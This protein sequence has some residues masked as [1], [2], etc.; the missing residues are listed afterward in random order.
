MKIAVFPGSFDPITNGHCELVSRAAQLFDEIIIAVGVN[1]SKQYM[2]PLEQRLQWIRDS[3]TASNIKVLTY[4]G[5]TIDFCVEQKAAYILR[6]LRNNADLEYER[7]IAQANATMA[8]EIETVFLISSPQT[9]FISSSIVRD[10][11]R[12]GGDYQKFVPPCVRI[13]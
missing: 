9:S 10:V 5:L 12:H 8:K 2:F 1:A 11:M 6:G 13:S 4:E 3:F 7:S